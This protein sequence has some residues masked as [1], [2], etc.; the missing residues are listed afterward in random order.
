M[1]WAPD[2]GEEGLHTEGQVHVFLMIVY[3]VLMY[4]ILVWWE[5]SNRTNRSSMERVK[6]K[7]LG[8]AMKGF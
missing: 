2:F 1:F 7:A 8:R 3:A 5:I 6:N 4:T